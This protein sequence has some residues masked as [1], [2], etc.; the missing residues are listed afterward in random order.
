MTFTRHQ[1][2]L[3]AAVAA[4]AGVAA[5]AF[6]TISASAASTGCAVTYTV[7]SQWSTGFTAS[8]AVTNL[9]DPISGWN[10]TWAFSAGQQVTQGWNATFTQSGAQ[11][12]ARNVSYNA[13]LATGASTTIGFNGSWSGSNPAPATFAVNG[14]SCNGAATSSPSPSVSASASPTGGTGSLPGSFRWTSTGALVGPHSNASHSLSGI[15]DP[16]VVYYNGKYHV[17]ASTTSSTGGYSM[18]Y[19][20]FAD[21]SQADSATQFYLDQTPIGSGYRAAP[22]IFY[23]A[24]QSTWYLVYQTGSNASYSTNSDISNPAGWS[25]PRGFYS[26]VPA[27]VQQNIGSGYWVD[28]WV[29]CDSANCY[30]FSS[31]D[32]GHLYR[33]QTSVASFPNGMSEPVIALQDADRHALFEASN[34]YKVS[35][36]NQYLLIVEAIG[37]GGKR[38]FRSWTSA[39][40]NGTWST[41]AATEASPFAGASNVTF[42]DGAWTTDISHGEMIRTGYDQTLTISPCKMRYLYQ[43]R[44]PSVSTGSYSTLP[45]RLALLT[46]ANPT[47]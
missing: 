13:S 7:G 15:K 39:S 45:W 17:F 29:I 36:T 24:P 18:V 32:N 35:G 42:S 19:F 20:S 47:C 3:A 21:W 40:I 22:Q 28:M 30:L 34:V 2:W 25:A 10:L 9:G 8:V 44:D 23:F 26:G 38:Y 46:Q 41:L 37:S 11:I 14:V 4:A 16:S 27:I 43:G 12:T 1:R 33:S 31:D 6:T 5:T